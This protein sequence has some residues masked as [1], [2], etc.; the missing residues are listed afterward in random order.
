LLSKLLDQ[1]KT[2]GHLALLHSW[3]TNCAT[4]WTHI[5]ICELSS[6]VSNFL[7]YKNLCM[8]RPLPIGKTRCI[9]VQMHNWQQNLGSWKVL[10][11]FFGLKICIYIPY[12]DVRKFCCINVFFF[13]THFEIPFKCKFCDSIH[14]KF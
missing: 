7:P 6:I 14:T 10:Q 2:S 8:T 4:I 11:R 3:K 12:K 13:P 9:I 1:L 5:L